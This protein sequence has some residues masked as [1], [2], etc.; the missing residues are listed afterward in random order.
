MTTTR[1][2]MVAG[3][4][5]IFLGD[6]GFGVEVAKR[7]RQETMPPE[8]HVEDFGIRGV[9]LAYALLDGFDTLILVDA[10]TRGEPAG[11][12]F[13][14]EPDLSQRDV[15]NP[16]LVDSHSL[17]PELVLGMVENLGGKLERILIVACEPVEVV[18][19]IG[20]SAPIESAVVQAM[21]LVRELVGEELQRERP[22]ANA[23]G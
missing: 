2:I 15:D 6:D 7:L 14:V 21:G 4:G 1:K 10:A 19:R 18:E 16:F 13:V 23:R 17:D 9:H 20:L 5:N 11:S 8:V 3:V 22:A 12:V